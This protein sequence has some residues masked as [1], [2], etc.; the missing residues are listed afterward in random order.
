MFVYNFSKLYLYVSQL[1]TKL[2][3]TLGPRVYVLIE[4]F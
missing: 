3:I 1:T 2:Q 4:I